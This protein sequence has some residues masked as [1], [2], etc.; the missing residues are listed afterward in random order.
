[1]MPPAEIAALQPVPENKR[2]QKLKSYV[3]E[4]AKHVA[5]VRKN[6][7]E[8]VKGVNLPF[9]YL[10]YFWLVPE[11]QHHASLHE[12]YIQIQ[13]SGFEGERI[14]RELEEILS[15]DPHLTECCESPLNLAYYVD[16]N[17]LS[18]FVPFIEENE[19]TDETYDRFFNTF[20]EVSYRQPFR[21][22]A[23]SHLYNFDS[24]E[25]LLRFAGVQIMRLEAG[26]IPGVI[27]DAS[28]YNFLHNHQT[29]D[30][31]VITD[32]SG[33][34][35]NVMDWLIDERATALNF[36]GILRYYKDGMVDIDYTTPY[37]LPEWVNQIRKRGP[38]FV[39]EPR[40][41]PYGD[42]TKFYRLS[43]V[44]ATEVDRWWRIYQTPQVDERLENL[45][46]ELR[47]VLLRAGD[48]YET[49]MQQKDSVTRLINLAIALEA[50]FSPSDQ[51]ELS[52]K[53]SLYASLL[54]SLDAKERIEN[55]RFVREMYDRR[56]KLFH[57]TYNVDRYQQ[58]TLVTNDE[59]E[60]LAAIIRISILRF[61]VLYLKGENSRGNILGE[62]S[63]GVL[64]TSLIDKLRVES[65][66]QTFIEQFQL[67][68]E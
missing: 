51:G 32:S 15:E 7:P 58:G 36:M 48:F 42:P 26:E 4:W 53:I 19:V 67:P 61:L 64:D 25:Q 40:R 41:V 33:E 18:M 65:D 5:S 21:K 24:T 8:L 10:C 37:F 46:N 43:Q 20:S 62:L 38:A 34:C 11:D 2:S 54:I 35:P 1:M 49:S 14:K 3:R 9:H 66:P 44:E 63:N 16:G 47:Q 39:G 59:M 60:R 50:L 30:Y 57:G 28:A 45:D 29:G 6:H 55:F 31:F 56:S 17:F 23:L 12:A 22:F 27:G 13:R 68:L 52:Y